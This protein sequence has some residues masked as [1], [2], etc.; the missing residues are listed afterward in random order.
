MR[1][2]WNIITLVALANLIAIVGFVWWLHFSGRLD[3]DR[4][5]AVRTMLSETI[6]E[7]TTREQTEEAQA[8]QEAADAEMEAKLDGSPVTA[9]EQLALRLEASEI[10]RQRLERLREEVEALS[11]TLARER[12]MFENERAAFVE[13]K[14]AFEAMR[15]R[16]AEIEGDE[17]FAKAVA[18]LE[19]VKSAEAKEMLG[20]LITTDPQQAV[21]YLDAMK[22]RQRA[23]VIAEFNKDGATDVA[24][25]L[26][27]QLRLHGLDTGVQ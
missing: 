15:E 16:L 9:Q 2:A 6:S 18:V 13:E 24:T 25:G 12:R 26:L 22:A 11:A 5:E 19:T 1:T 4:V 7:Q 27:E 20:E 21:A 17:Q 14:R 23:K 8:A 10:D 3:M